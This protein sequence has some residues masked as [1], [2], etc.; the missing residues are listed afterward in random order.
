MQRISIINI[1][2]GNISFVHL[3]FKSLGAQVDVVSDK[4]GIHDP[5]AIVLPGVGN[6]SH[7]MEYLRNAGYVEF[8]RRQHLNEKFPF[9][10]YALACSC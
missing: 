5:D 7:A 10:A 9:W 8:L 6:F 1:G 2:I 3:A 4:G